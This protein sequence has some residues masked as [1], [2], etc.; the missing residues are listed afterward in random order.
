MV[1]YDPAAYGDAWSR[2]YD[3]LFESRDDPGLSSGP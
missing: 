3:R 1:D 2:D